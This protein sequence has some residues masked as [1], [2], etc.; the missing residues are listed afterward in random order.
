MINLKRFYPILPLCL[1]VFSAVACTTA[2]S[3]TSSSPIVFLTTPVTQQ[4]VEKNVTPSIT[5]TMSPS[6]TPTIPIEITSTPTL[7]PPSS[8][9]TPTP[10]PWYSHPPFPVDAPVFGYVREP[11]TSRM[12]ASLEDAVSSSSKN[13]KFAYNVVYVQVLEGKQSGG[14]EYLKVIFDGHERWMRSEDVVVVDIA[15][16]AGVVMD[17]EGKLPSTSDSIGIVI[18][19]TVSESGGSYYRGEALAVLQID[20]QGGKVRISE[21]DDL[22]L[23]R[24]VLI[25]VSVERQDTRYPCRR[26]VVDISSNSLAAYDEACNLRFATLISTGLLP[27]STPT[28]IYRIASKEAFHTFRAPP[29]IRKVL[30]NYIFENVPFTMVFSGYYALHSVY[31]HNAF[32]TSTSHGCINLSLADAQWLY[33]W[34]DER[35]W[36]FIQW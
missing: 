17:E 6:V 22:P 30:E 29:E 26:I 32:G 18:T 23:E 13:Y 19:D 8:T 15:R 7:A 35:E 20:D 27:G 1:L 2:N 36:L 28:G 10:T 21:T 25:P 24:I 5:S 31:W 12:F 33:T 16:F 11:A 3:Q 14:K 34:A 9:P 4:V